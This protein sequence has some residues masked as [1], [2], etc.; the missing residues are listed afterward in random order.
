M[1]CVQSKDYLEQN[2]A[3]GR[4]TTAREYTEFC[5]R[6]MWGQKQMEFGSLVVGTGKPG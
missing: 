3:M 6:W 4:L 1:T 2:P 5:T